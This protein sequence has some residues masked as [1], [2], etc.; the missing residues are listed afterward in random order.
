MSS[1]ARG[2][3][4]A[5][6]R[7]RSPPEASRGGGLWNTPCVAAVVG[8]VLRFEVRGRRVEEQKFTSR[9]KRL[10]TRRKT[11]YCRSSAT[12]RRKSIARYA[13]HTSNS[14]IPG[15]ATSRST[16]SSMASLL[17]GANA[18]FATMA[19]MTRS[20][21]ALNFRSASRSRKTSSNPSCRHSSSSRYA[22]PMGRLSS[23]VVWM[24]SDWPRP[25]VNSS[26]TKR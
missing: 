11:S 21:A 12:S 23:S 9:F 7:G 4:P 8:L 1:S 18:R 15:R 2:F 14:V 22:P 24:P 17:L 20:T 10:L 3:R 5:S 16:H 13:C 26:P 19:K 6:P 25:E